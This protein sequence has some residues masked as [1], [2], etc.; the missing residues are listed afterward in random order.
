PLLLLPQATQAA[1]AKR[2]GG[3]PS[4]I[5][6]GRA[7]QGERLQPRFQRLQETF[8]EQGAKL[9]EAVNGAAIE[10]VVVLEVAGA[11]EDFYKAVRRSGLQWLID[12]D[13]D[14]VE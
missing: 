7:R 11:V 2:S 12:M 8:N 1:K 14:D 10:Q 6:P 13:G 3:G 9:Q 4:V 5:G